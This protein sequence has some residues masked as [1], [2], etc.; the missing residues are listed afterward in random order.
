MYEFI[1]PC[2]ISGGAKKIISAT[3]F[4][5][6]AGIGSLM[7]YRSSKMEYDESARSPI[8]E[9]LLNPNAD[10]TRV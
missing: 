3:V 7:A 1:G 9:S 5:F 2:T 10:D 6:M 4:W 8:E